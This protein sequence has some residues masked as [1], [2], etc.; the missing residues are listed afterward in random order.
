MDQG[1]SFNRS[2]ALSLFTN[3]DRCGVG[4]SDEKWLK[5][6]NFGVSGDRMEYRMVRLA[7]LKTTKEVA[8][9]QQLSTLDWKTTPL[10]IPLGSVFFILLNA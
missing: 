1:S 9:K 4:V 7:P 10:Q 6:M 2:R 5:E 3:P 8:N